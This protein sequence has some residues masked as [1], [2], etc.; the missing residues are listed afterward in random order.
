MRFWLLF[1]FSIIPSIVFGGVGDVYYCVSDVNLDIN[2]GKVKQYKNEKFKFQRTG[3][4]LKF[5]QSEGY[6]G[7]LNLNIKIYDIGSGEL[8][9]YRDDNNFIFVYKGN[10]FNLSHVR[11][12]T[13]AV[14][15]GTCNI[16]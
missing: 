4:E 5:K 2:K 15:S 11:Y 3:N 7:S 12:D 8:F 6:I 16:F 14:M 10:R 13:F 9:D 1:V